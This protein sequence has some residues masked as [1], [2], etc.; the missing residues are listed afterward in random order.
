MGFD[1]VTIGVGGFSQ[2]AEVTEEVE[3]PPEEAVAFWNIRGYNVIALHK[4]IDSVRDG[5]FDVENTQSINLD[6]LV[7]SQCIEHVPGFF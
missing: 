6:N 2:T 3:G 4:T 1:D 5:S 7:S